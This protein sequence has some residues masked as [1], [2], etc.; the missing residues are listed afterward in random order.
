MPL[1]STGLTPTTPQNGPSHSATHDILGLDHNNFFPNG[2]DTAGAIPA[3]SLYTNTYGWGAPR[4]QQH[5]DGASGTPITGNRPNPT[6]TVFR[7][8]QTGDL[9]LGV[10]GGALNVNVY[11]V[12]SSGINSY[13]FGT[14]QANGLQVF[15]DQHESG[16]ALTFGSQ[17]VMW[18]VGGRAYSYY[19]NLETLSHA[20]TISNG[21]GVSDAV[22]TCA[23]HR[24]Y[25][26]SEV[27]FASRVSVSDATI[28]SPTEITTA[29]N[30]GLSTGEVVYLTVTG[31]TV[32]GTTANFAGDYTVTVTAANKFTVAVN[33][34]AK[35][36]VGGDVTS[37]TLPAGISRHTR[38][39]VVAVPTK[40][41]F[42]VSTSVGGSPVV[43]SSA[44][45]G[46][47]YVNGNGIASMN[48]LIINSSYIDNIYNQSGAVFMANLTLQTIANNAL[49]GMGIW[50]V[51]DG[52]NMQWSEGIVFDPLSIRNQSFYDL[53][54][55]VTS[56]KIAG[57]HTDGIDFSAG[58]FSNSMIKLDA[59]SFFN[60]AGGLAEWQV[61]STDSLTYVR[62]TNALQLYVAS[63]AVWGVAPNYMLH[64]SLP[65]ASPGA[66]TKQFWYDPADG[67]RVK[68]AA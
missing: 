36:T 9:A 64:A 7:V 10:D 50:F 19:N 5:Y 55:S 17:V 30:H 45:S 32:N 52:T 18:N 21:G 62:S 15:I 58:T 20:C 59:N 29:S 61:D 1:L 34:T 38:Y 48:P 22:I 23:D 63:A 47:F 33:V 54:S 28:A 8:I 66:G 44:G 24:L 65:A 40:D 67:N 49:A 16:D 13:T 68:Y 6:D 14:A 3:A 2:P 42:K 37:I 41:T 60:I 43:T 27:Q 4:R 31:V 46:T 35:T 11:S 51:G 25:V 56:L 57:S 12:A 53:S 39:F 26:N